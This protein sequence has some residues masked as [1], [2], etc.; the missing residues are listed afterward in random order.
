MTQSTVDLTI[1]LLKDKH[2]NNWSVTVNDSSDQAQICGLKDK[3]GKK[4]YFESDAY[5]ISTWAKENDIEFKKIIKQ[6][7]FNSLWDNH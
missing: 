3:S 2:G 5:H 6:E 7:D 1:F 4:V